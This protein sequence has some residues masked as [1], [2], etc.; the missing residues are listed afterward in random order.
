MTGDSLFVG[1]DLGTSSLKAVAV[2]AGGEVAARAHAGYPTA[3]PE[4][5]AA[6]QSPADWWA[7]VESAVAALRA[8]GAP[9]ERWA[10]IGLS[11]MIPRSR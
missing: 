4:P 7:T 5:G 2:G 3:R 8:G 9:P 11:G 10:A 6:E 1:L